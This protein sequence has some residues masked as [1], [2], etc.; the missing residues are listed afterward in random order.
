MS[1]SDTSTD[2]IVVGAGM[3]GG[4]IAFLLARAGVR[5]TLLEQG[6]EIRDTDHAILRDEW[7]WGISREWSFNPNIRG[8]DQD[9]PVTGSGFQPYM[10]NGVGGS[11]NHY[12]GYWHRLKPVDFRKGTEHGLEGTIDWPITHEELAPYYRLNDRYVGVSGHAGDPAHPD[13]EPAPCPPL[14]HGRYNKLVSQGLDR[15]G[16]HWWPGE[17]A[18]ISEPYEG[19]LPCNLC[20]MCTMGCPRGSLGTSTQAYIRRALPLGLD[21]RPNVRVIRVSTGSSG[22]VDGV[23]LV[24]RE[25]GAGSR[26]DAP[27][28][29]VACNGIGSP[30]LL[31]NSASPQHPDGLANDQDVVGR[32]LIL[33]GYR[34]GDLW[35]DEPTEHYKGPWGAGIYC[36]EYYDTDTG[37]G[38]V[39]GM[40]LTFGGGFGPATSALGGVTGITPAPWGE[41]HRR[42]FDQRFDHYVFAAIQTE[43]LPVPTNRVTLDPD[44]TD[45]SGMPAA[46]VHYELHDNDRTLL[47]F[48][49]HRVREVA[50]AAGARAV[51][52]QPLDEGPGMADMA[53]GAGRAPGEAPNEYSPPG[54]H[55]MGTCR[56]GSGP[57]DSVVDKWHRAW[58]V[59][60][61]VVCDGS[62]MTTGGAGN[63][64]STIGA[65]AVRCGEQ[66]VRDRG[67]K[68]ESLAIAGD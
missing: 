64:T 39:N 4:A 49:S 14:K 16:W 38:A 42:E 61:L 21:L 46:H 67:R 22:A 56:M 8:L 7:E 58:N 44:E 6:P 36:S 65:L 31:L 48:G 52:L 54:W 19:R 20:G 24:D 55:L 41:G 10:Y 62:S 50:E 25:T 43:D 30:R 45:S 51:D 9:Y 40:T 27:L 15:L 53:S 57:S 23:E 26:I 11:T 17:N 60:G 59:P 33:H 18:I 13:R 1:R 3:A 2:A 37:R 5:V 34:L 32:H 63:P 12:A 29:V 28:V 68:I 35:F 47:A 66:L